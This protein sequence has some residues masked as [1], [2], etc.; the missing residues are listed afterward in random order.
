[1]AHA[2][3]ESSETLNQTVYD[4]NLLESEEYL[5]AQGKTTVPLG[6]IEN[7]KI[8]VRDLSSIPHIL[9]CGFTGTGKTSFVQTLLSVMLL[10]RPPFD[11]NIIIYDSKRIEYEAFANAPHLFVPVIYER[12]KALAM[13]KYLSEESFKRF[14]LLAEAGCKDFEQYNTLQDDA[15]KLPEIFYVL[16]DFSSLY[17]DKASMNELLSVLRNG[18]IVGIH[19]YI[20]SSMAS[21]KVLQKELISN[22]SCRICF[23]LLSKTESRNILEQ[24]GAEELFIPGEM[25]Y[26]FQ[27]ESYK[28]QC[29]YTPYGNIDAAMKSICKDAV[30]V[31]V[32]GKEASALFSA[33]DNTLANSG[34]VID[35]DE[36]LVDAA[37]L[38]I[39]SKNASIK[40]LQNQFQIG[41]N[42]A[43]RIMD[44]LQSLGVVGDGFGSKPREVLMDMND[45]NIVCVSKKLKKTDSIRSQLRSVSDP[46]SAGENYSTFSFSADSDNEENKEP[47][48]KLRDFAE[49]AIGEATIS[50]HDHKIHFSKPIMTRLGP[51]TITPS[52][53]G[54]YVTRLIYKKPTVFSRGYMTFEFDP[55]TEIQNNN[56]Y[57][58]HVDINNVS[59][60]IKIEFGSSQNRTICLF[61]KQLSEDIGVPI[62]QM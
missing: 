11:V 58:L 5:S 9:V 47:K 8:L 52:F 28:C 15:K 23:R 12:D 36:Y 50:V 41:F 38:F 48:I 44:Q 51:G 37:E 30:S 42:K 19:M 21:T 22:I 33:I 27:N 10:K 45:W 35:Y 24:N 56:P 62:K 46:V 7:G 4:D 34:T 26:K 61:L 59:E 25:I 53:P 49:F 60:L 17:I 40:L 20:V 57:L 54:K 16:D 1:M 3:Q 14:E 32:L 2:Y 29:A 13:L 39:K 55:N 18:R 6:I 31:A 43:A